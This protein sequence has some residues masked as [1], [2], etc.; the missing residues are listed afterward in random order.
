MARP[1]LIV[2][3]GFPGV[4]KSVASAYTADQ[5]PAERYRSDAIRKE[6]FSDPEYTA[7][8]TEATYAELFER[9]RAGLETGADVVLDATFRS[10]RYRDRAA[11]VADDAG[12]DSLFVRVT[13]DPDV[14]VERLENRT[15]TVSD[16]GVRE[17]RIVSESFEPLERE[18]VE[19]DNSGSLDET[20]RQI[21]RAVLSAED[22]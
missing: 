5:L 12:V 15:E 22:T 17:Y 9:A 1:T 7:A 4:G 11:G 2:Y 19:I 18:H 20:Y 13:C 10:R 6:L 14:A 16:A 8:E 21:D 3:C